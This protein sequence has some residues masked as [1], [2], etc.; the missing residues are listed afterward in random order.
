MRGRKLSQAEALEEYALYRIR[1]FEYLHVFQ[2]L[3]DIIDGAYCPKD[4]MG[5]GTKEYIATLKDSATGLFV[6]LMDNDK[7]AIN[8]FDVWLALFPQYEERIRAVWGEIEPLEDLLRA[9]RN[10]VVYHVENDIV[11][12]LKTRAELHEKRMEVARAMQGFVG[13]ARDLSDPGPLPHFREEFDAILRRGFPDV[14]DEII[15]KLKDYIVDGKP[16]D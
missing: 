15:E 6:S 8:V 9:Y 7:R 1:L 12:Y 5:H 13:L 3:I 16:E 2:V 11:S 14:R 10:K 4:A